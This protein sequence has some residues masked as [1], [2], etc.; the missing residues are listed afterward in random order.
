MVCSIYQSFFLTRQRD[1][2]VRRAFNVLTTELAKYNVRDASGNAYAGICDAILAGTFPPGTQLN[3]R[4]LAE[5]FNVSRTPIR[6]ALTRLATEG[7]VRQI[8][9]IGVFVRKLDVSEAID[10]L[11][12]RQALEAVAAERVARQ[13][14]PEQAESL[15][16]LAEEVDA[17]FVRCDESDETRCLEIEFHG[18]VAKLSG[19]KELI[20]MLD[21]VK[22]VYLTVFPQAIRPSIRT[23]RA[24]MA[25]THADSGHR[26]PIA[27]PHTD[28]ARAIASKDPK[29][30]HQAMWDH[31]DVALVELRSGS[32]EEGGTES[33]KP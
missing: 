8:P 23:H 25:A 33:E 3:E 22:T 29:K 6:D 7:L 4:Q 19:N 1:D 24:R 20:R 10:L 11:E 16:Q 26:E 31:L 14:T 15:L 13:V 9:Y 28:V 12:I 17:S 2:E 32:A 18:T 21:N 30:A 27:A 5:Q